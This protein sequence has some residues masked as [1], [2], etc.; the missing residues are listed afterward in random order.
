MAETGR[1]TL[2]ASKGCGSA[3]VEACL[4]IAGLPYALEELDYGPP[5]PDRDRLLS[6]NPLCQVPTLILP[7][8]SVMTESAAMAIHIAETAPASLLAPPPGDPS[9]AAF[10]R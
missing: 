2:L 8:G 4:D 10:L 9:R 6:L 1:Y 7:G 5:G 3:I